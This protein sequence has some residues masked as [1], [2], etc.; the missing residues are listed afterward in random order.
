MG[1]YLRKKRLFLLVSYLRW[2]T[3]IMKRLSIVLLSL[4]LLLGAA[5]CKR[6]VEPETAPDLV[7]ILLAPTTPTVAPL[8]TDTPAPTQTPIPD[9]LTAADGI[10]TIAWISDTQHYSRQNNGVYECMTAFLA[11]H[12]ERMRLAYIVH[13]GDLVHNRDIAAEWE[14][15]DRAM[16]TIDHIPNGVLAG[17]HD[18][19]TKSEECDY[20]YYN[21]YFGESRYADKPWYGESFQNNRGHYDRIDAGNTQYLFLYLG[22]HITEEG[23]AWA[24]DVLAAYPDCVGILCAHDYFYHDC[25]L[26]EQGQLLYDGLVTT[27]SNLYAVLCGHRYNSKC[28]PIELDDTGDGIPDRTVLQMIA[29]YQAIG[30][31]DAPV[32]TGGDG[33]M[34]FLQVDEDA[35]II[36]FYS[37]SPY[38][39]DYTYFDEPAHQM[40]NYAFDPAGEQGSIPIPWPY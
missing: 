3:D 35:G 19:G 17:N 7:D 8:P 26:T 1:Q 31:G 39:D 15:A 33:Y 18:V 38:L 27:C 28:I 30:D 16:D 6:N 11:E 37:Y 9:A 13:T 4:L 29:N 12:A 21:M 24:K 22:Y 32:L 10:Y 20:S 36:R 14:I 25:T 34:R 5:G 23:I 40:E 2:Y